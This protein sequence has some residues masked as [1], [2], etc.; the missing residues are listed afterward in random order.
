M[1]LFLRSHQHEQV[2]I[3]A[4]L[5]VVPLSQPA[6]SR[7]VARLEARGLLVRRGPRMTPARS[8]FA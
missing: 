2:R 8:W 1:L 3:G 5:E 7:L 6:L 4:L